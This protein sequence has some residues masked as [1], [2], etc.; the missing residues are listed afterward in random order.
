MSVCVRTCFYF[1]S[2]FSSFLSLFSL[3]HSHCLHTFVQAHT[4]TFYCCYF[5]VLQF[6][7]CVRCRHTKQKN[8]LRTGT[9]ITAN[10]RICIL[11]IRIRR[12]KFVCTNVY[13]CAFNLIRSMAIV[14]KSSVIVNECDINACH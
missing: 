10:A 11:Y 14:S 5:N 8:I 13:V 6:V 12:S 3:L 9:H 1:C 4:H 2:F 7:T